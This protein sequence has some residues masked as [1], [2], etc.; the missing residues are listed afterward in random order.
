MSYKLLPF[1]FNRYDD[2]CFIS[3]M[4][5]N[6]YFLNKSNF[7]KF[8]NRQFSLENDSAILHD[9]E[10]R[11]FLY[12]DGD[13]ATVVDLLAT[14]YRTRKHF[15]ADFTSLHMMVITLR[16]NHKCEYCQV[17]SEES[18]AFKYDMAP[19]TAKRIV[20]NIFQSPSPCIKIEFQGGEPLLNWDTIVATVNYAKELN[21]SYN[22][23]L[24]F[25]ICTNL[26]LL[27]AKHFALIK[28]NRI[29]ISTSLDGTRLLHDKQRVMRNC[30]SS[31]DLF[32]K[33]LDVAREAFG[34]GS[35]DALMTTT[36][37]NIDQIDAVVDE[38]IS[39][40]FRG[41][42]FRAL[43][44]YGDASKNAPK[45]GY[46]VDKFVD[47]Y[48]KGLD[49]I[50][51][52]NLEGRFFLE[53]YTTLLLRRILTPF[54]TGFV[55]LQFPSGAGISGAIYDYNGDVFPA[56]EARM[57]KRMGD[58]K[59][60]MGNVFRN[61]YRDI[62]NG[63]VIREIAEK[64]CAEC[65]PECS[66]CAYQPYCGADPIRNY[67]ETNDIVGY[68]PLSDF[69]KK[70]MLIFDFLFEKIKNNNPDEMDVFW[71]WITGR[72]LKDIRCEN[73]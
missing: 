4:A 24:D 26:T 62:F 5:G 29:A 39:L 33:K 27:E 20:E 23:R 66:S 12:R 45:L 72:P 22:K 7:A 15:I 49:Y 73:N 47:A 32:R 35:V 71:S 44:P 30:S 51:K 1:S 52:K 31:Y 60:L 57:L 50:I 65:M 38:Y 53:Y 18:D 41:I 25:V 46:K 3:N 58:S 6:F 11:H 68:R 2:G 63:S 56:D 14:K 8:I 70:H 21:K 40:G 48:K 17:S 37:T 34:T 36:V 28:E 19:E 55:D 16:C 13:L 64:T 10:S 61:T 9:L 43:N 69:C 67:L 59:F 42:F 54:S